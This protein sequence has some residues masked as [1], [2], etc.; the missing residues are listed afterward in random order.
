MN[1]KPDHIILKGQRTALDS[2]L[3]RQIPHSPREKDLCQFLSEWYSEDDF[4]SVNTSGSTGIPKQIKLKKDFVAASARR[5]I[6]YFKLKEKSRVLHSLPIKYIAGKL[7]LV[8]ALMGNLDL[9]LIDPASD[10]K[11]LGKE[12]FEFAAMV[13]NQVSKFLDSGNPKIKHL[14]IGGDAIPSSLEYKLQQ[15]ST[16]CYSSYGMTETATHIAI[17]K[18][19]GNNADTHYRCLTGIKI[20]LSENNC[21]QITMPG[22]EN[23]P[24]ITTDIAEIKDETSFAILG[25]ADNIIIS[26]GI[27]YSPEAIEKKLSEKI[28]VPYMISSEPN[29]K[30][31]KQLI[32]ILETEANEEYEKQ[33]ENIFENTLLRFERPRRISF[34]NKLPCTANGKLIRI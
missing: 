18:L 10:F 6:D 20:S 21:L 27:K 32:I 16:A 5:T 4:I 15:T 23:T 24:L 1:L 17:R 31:G 8:R 7:M 22:L 2:L 9:T 29:E 3:Q 26:G 30:L 34:T 13:P 19:N 12:T 28:T 11:E 25:R 14:L 33:L